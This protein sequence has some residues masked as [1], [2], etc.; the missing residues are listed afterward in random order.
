LLACADGVNRVAFTMS[1]SCPFCPGKRTSTVTNCHAINEYT[2]LVNRASFRKSSFG[3]V[4]DTNTSPRCFLPC[5]HEFRL[6]TIARSQFGR[7]IEI[8]N[9]AG[10]NWHDHTP[11]FSEDGRRCWRHRHRLLRL[12]SPARCARPAVGT[13]EITRHD[14]WQPGQN[15]RRARPLPVPRSR[16]TAR[17]QRCR[18]PSSDLARRRAHIH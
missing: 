2:P 17:R 15:D 8:T 5:D 13:A 1:A 4:V 3:K 11:S 14:R 6:S 12:R 18:G 10:G 9:Y 16:R 7:G